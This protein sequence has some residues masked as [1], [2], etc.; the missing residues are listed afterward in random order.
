MIFLTI[1]QLF[2]GPDLFVV[3]ETQ[4]YN[5]QLI[6]WHQ[7][8]RRQERQEAISRVKLS[9]HYTSKTLHLYYADETG[10]RMES[11]TGEFWNILLVHVVANCM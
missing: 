9:V 2:E 6:C 10:W 4:P 5:L 7:G 8:P 11:N 3:T 1:Y